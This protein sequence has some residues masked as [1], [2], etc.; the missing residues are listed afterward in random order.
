MERSVWKSFG[1]KR[2]RDTAGPIV[3]AI[4]VF[5]LFHR[6]HLEFLEAARALGSRLVVAVNG[7]EMVTSYKR[8]PVHCE[9]DRLTIVRALRCVDQAF[10]IRGYDNK[11]ALMRHKVDM[12]V[13]GDDWKPESY[14]KQIVVDQEFLDR[15]R[16]VLHFVPYYKG[17]STS[18]IIRDLREQT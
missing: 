6:G 9:A 15:N 3:Y 12:I 16:I 11:P 7:D 13:H 5:D 10:V 8:K 14:M 18:A 4:G 17:V 1:A 2:S